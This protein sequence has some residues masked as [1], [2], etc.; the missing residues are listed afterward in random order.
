MKVDAVTIRTEQVP[1]VCQEGVAYTYSISRWLPLNRDNYQT[2]QRQEALVDRISM[3]EKILIGNILSFAKGVRIFFDSPVECRILELVSTGLIQYKEVELMLVDVYRKKIKELLPEP[4]GISVIHVM[5]ESVFTFMLVSLL[6]SEQ[7]IVF[8][9][10]T[11]RIVSYEG[12]K[13]ISTF[14]FVRFRSYK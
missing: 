2:Y 10:T 1:V 7:Y 6:L 14:K 12:D 5:G 9:S 13:K 3:L 11:E 8:A 4:D